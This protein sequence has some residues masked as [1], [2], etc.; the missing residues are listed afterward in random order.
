[1][2]TSDGGEVETQTGQRRAGPRPGEETLVG[3][4]ILTGLKN[5]ELARDRLLAAAM[6]FSDGEITAQQLRA[7]REFYREQ[8]LL[9]TRLTGSQVP[10][11]TEERTAPPA[12]EPVPEPQAPV[13]AP[14]EP[15]QEVRLAEEA[16]E[17]IGEQLAGLERKMAR[18]EQDFALGN[19]NPTQ[20]KAVRRHYH[21]Q[22]DVALKLHASNPSSERW[23]IVLEEGKTVFL[24]QLNEA[25]CLGFAIYDTQSRSRVF[26]EGSMGR[27]A[28]EAM[29]LLGTFGPPTA[30][31]TGR[32]LATRTD[33][34][35]SLLLIPGQHTVALVRFTSDPPGWQV[36]ALREV[37]RNF[38]AANHVSLARGERITLVFPDV[39]R[40]VKSS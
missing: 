17:E 18:L 4:E 23:R 15:R 21:E 7:V 24:L 30:S 11:F 5:L 19:I 8:D 2:R 29:A 6:A 34:G 22:R 16:G 39:S 20:Y 27:S 26:L 13:A 31:G 35:D 32:M 28:E 25:A 12:P 33:D 40:I 3:P 38:E 10:P 9:L 1:M 14:V 37:H 36:R